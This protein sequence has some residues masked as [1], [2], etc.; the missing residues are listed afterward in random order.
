MTRTQFAMLLQSSQSQLWDTVVAVSYVAGSVSKFAMVRNPGQERGKSV[1]AQPLYECLR[2]AQSCRISNMTVNNPSLLY[3]LNWCLTL[4]N[5][6][7]KV[8]QL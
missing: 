8:I 1:R 2:F 7:Q 4:P 5:L 6:V 3:F